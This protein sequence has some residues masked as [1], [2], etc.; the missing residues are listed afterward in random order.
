M[1][2]N[3]TNTDSYRLAGACMVS[4]ACFGLW[5]GGAVISTLMGGPPALAAY[6]A[7]SI[8]SVS[9]AG[10]TV[11]RA[12]EYKTYCKKIPEN[13]R[14]SFLKFFT[15]GEPESGNG[16]NNTQ[17]INSYFNRYNQGKKFNSSP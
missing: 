8:G 7:I 6:L 12:I 5:G 11:K 9:I 16:F 1:P 3:S 4:T 15:F 14:I 17:P 2:E 13:E 10:Y